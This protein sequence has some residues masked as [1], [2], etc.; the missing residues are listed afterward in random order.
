MTSKMALQLNDL[1][2]PVSQSKGIYSSNSSEEGDSNQPMTIDEPNGDQK[3]TEEPLAD[4]DKDLLLI[5]QQTAKLKADS[6]RLEFEELSLSEVQ[7]RVNKIKHSP[8]E[9]NHV[10]KSIKHRVKKKDKE[11]V[12][13]Y[14]ESHKDVIMNFVGQEIIRAFENEKK[15]AKVLERRVKEREEVNRVVKLLKLL[16][17]NH[18]TYYDLLGVDRRA[19][20]AEIKKARKNFVFMLHPDRNK[21]KSALRCTK[22]INNAVDILCSKE[23]RAEYDE[24]LPSQ[25]KAPRVDEEDLF[26]E[27]FANGA[28]DDDG[29]D[30]TDSESD[31]KSDSELDSESDSEMDSE[32][33]APMLS[34]GVMKI[35]LEMGQ[36]VLKPFF[37][38][39]DDKPDAKGLKK[40]LKEYNMLIE[41][42]NLKRR[43]RIPN[44]FMVPDTS[45]TKYHFMGRDI[46]TWWEA[47]RLKPEG[48]QQALQK[49]QNN[50]DKERLHSSHQWPAEWTKLLISPLRKRL[51][52]LNLPK[53]QTRTKPM[54][55][56]SAR[57][58][59]INWASGTNETSDT[60][61]PDAYKHDE[62]RLLGILAHASSV[63]PDTGGVGYN[64]GMG[65]SGTKYFFDV[66][67]LNK[68]EVKMANE[69]DPEETK[70]YHDSGKASNINDQ[71]SEYRRLL[72]SR[73]V[74]VIGVSFLPGTGN[75]ER[76]CWTYV[77]VKILNILG[78]RIMTR[79]TLR[80]W[81]GQREADKRIDAF[82]VESKTVPPWAMDDYDSGK[83]KSYSLKYPLPKKAHGNHQ[84]IRKRYYDDSDDSDDEER[85]QSLRYK[86][87]VRHLGDS[88]EISNLVN[89]KVN[90]M[91][92]TITKGIED[93]FI[94]RKETFEKELKRLK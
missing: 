45:I 73:F 67:G 40:K 22:A 25:Y 53:E 42:Q 2:A 29:N 11:W 19:T 6:T 18:A 58:K 47:R 9:W 62:R 28:F 55:G 41:E 48:V 93:L 65:Y 91:V 63:R 52:K 49:L 30:S 32:N 88:Q 94:T 20:T 92:E 39:L 56:N 35:Y 68:L 46:M 59:P 44:L 83:H 33:E 13:E 69:V 82:L 8:D 60:D 14:I 79:S 15:K 4:C 89:L 70:K 66:E 7:S 54:Q 86:G 43:I 72:R 38:S 75:Y 10:L 76:T 87:R 80:G 21:D 27:E 26:D 51:I 37:K 77:R 3:T 1:S 36:S 57:E 74:R 84:I 81:L 16:K 50:F 17:K 71:E 78:G 12:N 61:M 64:G 31:S 90:D 85:S 34:E 5:V 24:S 23:K